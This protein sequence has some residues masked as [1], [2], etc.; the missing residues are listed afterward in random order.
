MAKTITVNFDDDGNAVIETK[1]FS[2]GECLSATKDL[3][4]ALGVTTKETATREMNSAVA[5]QQQKQSQ[6]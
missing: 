1:G 6:R 4:S 5:T 3:K 2:G